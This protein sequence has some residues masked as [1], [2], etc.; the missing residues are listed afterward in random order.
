MNNRWRQLKK[1]VSEEDFYWIENYNTPEPKCP[2]CYG[3]LYKQSWDEE[4]GTV[5]THEECICSYSRN[6]SYGYT[7]LSVGNWDEGYEYN[8]PYEKSKLIEKEFE[9]QIIMTRERVKKMRK[10]L[11]RKRRPI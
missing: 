8:T 6:W 3:R 2:C 10:K 5:E 1:F 9:E 4:R 7:S 11:Y